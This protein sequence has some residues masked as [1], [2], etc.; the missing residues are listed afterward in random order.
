[1]DYWFIKMHRKML[2]WEWYNDINTKV[3]FL[4]LL[5]KANWEDKQ[6]KWI[7]IEKWE[8]LSSLEHLSKETWLTTQNIRTSITRLK[9]TGELTNKSTSQY[10]LFKLNNYDTYQGNQQANQQTTKELKE[11]K[12]VKENNIAYFSEEKL[13]IKFLEFIKFRKDIKKRMTDNAIKL[14]QWKINKWLNDYKLDDV[15][16]F[17]DN[18]IINNYQWV[19]EKEEKKKIKT[20]NINF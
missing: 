19:F 11:I 18:S 8:V 7:T 16:S 12:E 20:N 14:L 1:M 17:I 4:H 5:L 3:L 6:W 10:T 9:S 2:D 15:I 13:N